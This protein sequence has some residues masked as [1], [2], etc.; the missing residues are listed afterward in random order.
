MI[1]YTIQ[2][3]ITIFSYFTVQPVSSPLSNQV[4]LEHLLLY[5]QYQLII[6][7]KLN[8]VIENMQTVTITSD[9]VY[10]NTA[11]KYIFI[12]PPGIFL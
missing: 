5:T 1:K 8:M 3:F 11:S 2:Y 4:V 7:A 6:R 12:C 9:T 10:F